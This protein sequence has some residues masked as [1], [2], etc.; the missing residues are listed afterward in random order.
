MI[1]ISHRWSHMITTGTKTPPN[2]GITLSNKRF[3]IRLLSSYWSVLT[4]STNTPYRCTLMS[5]SSYSKT[6]HSRI[7]QTWT[8]TTHSLTYRS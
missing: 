6:A 5:Y 4:L 2:T 7:L 3:Q 8:N 1:L